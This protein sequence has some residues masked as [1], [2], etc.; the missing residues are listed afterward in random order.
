MGWIKLDDGFFNN[1]K[2][3][4]VGKDAKVLYI[5]GLCY[6]GAALTDGSIPKNAVH[7]L[8]AQ[9]GVKSTR[10]PATE[11][12]EAGLWIEAGD[13][14][15]VHDYHE[16]N[17]RAQDVREKRQAARDRMQRH[18][19]HDVRANNTRSSPEVREPDTDTDT[20]TGSSFGTSGENAREARLAPEEPL[21]TTDQDQ[22]SPPKPVAP[23]PKPKR[24]TQLPKGF[25]LTE[26][27]AEMAAKKGLSQPEAE[28][29]F[30]KFCE[31]HRGEGSIKADWDATWRTWLG[32]I[33]QYRPRSPTNGTGRA[34]TQLERAQASQERLR[35]EIAAAK[36]GNHDTS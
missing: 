32:R 5:A 2:I 15:Q 34:P 27:R 18:R 22:V 1:V 12:V 23:V 29:E 6:S 31:Y 19:S 8:G 16:Y 36:A 33:D 21:V 30:E 26:S 25:S 4:S 20:D 35:R 3:V 28:Y 14:Y 13:R 7:I 9:A 24:R 10:K 11:L 17:S